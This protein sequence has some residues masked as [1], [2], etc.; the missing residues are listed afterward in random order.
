MFDFA[1][2][3]RINVDVPYTEVTDGS[4]KSVF[5]PAADAYKPLT[6]NPDYYT[7]WDNALLQ[8]LYTSDS[9]TPRANAVVFVTDGDPTALNNNH[10][11]A[12]EITVPARGHQFVREHAQQSRSFTPTSSSRRARTSSPSASATAS[13]A[14]PRSPA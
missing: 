14:P 11:K 3:A 10:G 4:L 1:L 7:N 6:K 5:N 2:N 13:P 9:S 8:A 12:T